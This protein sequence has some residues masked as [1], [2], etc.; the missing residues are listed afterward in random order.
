MNILIETTRS[1]S[2][3]NKDQSGDYFRI[4]EKKG[5]ES[6]SRLGNFVLQ[7]QLKSLMY[8]DRSSHG[9][10]NKD[11]FID[12]LKF[13][14]LREFKDKENKQ[15]LCWYYTKK[16]GLLFIQNNLMLTISSHIYLLRI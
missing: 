7:E 6:S 9:D 3:T 5:K 2:R 15:V 8:I 11:K 14:K 12:E 16:G 13:I 10:P 4:D 1:S